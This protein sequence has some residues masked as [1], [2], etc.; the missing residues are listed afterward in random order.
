MIHIAHIECLAVAVYTKTECVTGVKERK[1]KQNKQWHKLKKTTT[2]TMAMDSTYS[3]NVYH[4]SFGSVCCVL[5]KIGTL[6]PFTLNRVHHVMTTI[7]ISANMY[8]Q[9]QYMAINYIYN[10]LEWIMSNIYLTDVLALSSNQTDDMNQIKFDFYLSYL[11]LSYVFRW[12]FFFNEIEDIKS[13]Q[14][15]NSYHHPPTRP[16]KIA[17]QVGNKMLAYTHG[18]H[19]V[20]KGYRMYWCHCLH[21]QRLYLCTKKGNQ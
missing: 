17:K 18:I 21:F 1:K 16:L 4:S 9:T 8:T 3:G 20:N 6:N 19:F 11:S 2:T 7:Q 12:F 13:V 14:M 15:H 5:A 10:I